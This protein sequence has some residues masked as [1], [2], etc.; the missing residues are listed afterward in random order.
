MIIGNRFDLCAADKRRYQISFNQVRGYNEPI[1]GCSVAKASQDD[2]LVL[3]EMIDAG[4]LC[5]AID[6]TYPL[7]EAAEAVRYVGSGQARAKVVITM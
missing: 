7:R 1:V 2:L 5:P 6:R 4:Q 3:K